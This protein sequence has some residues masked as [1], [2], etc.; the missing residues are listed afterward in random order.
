M[1]FSSFELIKFHSVSKSFGPKNVLTDVS[2]SISCGE[3]FALIGENGS[4]KSTLARLMMGLECPDKGGIWISPQSKMG[5][6]PQDSFQSFEKDLSIQKFLLESQGHLETISRRLSELENLMAHLPPSKELDQA[7]TEW[8][9]L[10]DEFNDFNGYEAVERSKVCLT[11]L[12][13]DHLS[14]NQSISQLSEGER[15]RV[16]LASLLLKN[17]NLLILD[18]PTNHLDHH[19][20]KWLEEYLCTF[21]GAVVLISH[22]RYFLNQVATGMIELSSTTHQLSYYSGNYDVY[23]AAKKKELDHRLELYE[24]QREELSSLKKFVKAQTFSSPKVAPPKDAN[25]MAYDRHGEKFANSKR[26]KISQAKTKIDQIESEKLEHPIPKGY[27]G[28][29]FKPKIPLETSVA[30]TLE[31]IEVEIGGKLLINQ[32]SAIAHSRER[33]ILVGPNGSGKSTFLKLLA[34]QEPP[35]A[36]KFIFSSTAFIGFLPQDAV[37]SHEKWTILEYLQKKFS[38][39]ERQL[40]SELHQIALIE[41]RFI[42]QRIETLSLG[43]KRRLQL[44]ELMLQGANILLLDEPTNHLAPGVID[45]LEDALLIF[46]G[47]IIAATHDRRFASRVGTTFWQWGKVEKQ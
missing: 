4:G 6:L 14:S 3:R 15:R 30:L 2:F 22:D 8:G 27:K 23:L 29:I 35:K 21:R 5:Y 19:A 17:P 31:D 28:I 45:Q 10:Y 24:K 44:L 34:F 26:K 11:A 16:C 46:P 39:P 18:E 13:L 36:G 1:P 41:D 9:V 7:I 37:F 42:T 12:G 43:Q 47:T 33:I 40:R 25:K 32:F 38:L 20:L